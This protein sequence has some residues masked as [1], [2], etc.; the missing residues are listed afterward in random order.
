MVSTLR[1]PNA[2]SRETNQEERAEPNQV[3]TEVNEKKIGGI[4][5]VNQACDKNQNQ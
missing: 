2:A 3:P 5:E 1:A 4:N